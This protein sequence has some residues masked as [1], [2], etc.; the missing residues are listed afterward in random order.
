MGEAWSEFYFNE[1][2]IHGL[3]T[4]H[5][6]GIFFEWYQAEGGIELGNPVRKI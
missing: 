2:P 5:Q 3:E 4:N 6:Y 1:L